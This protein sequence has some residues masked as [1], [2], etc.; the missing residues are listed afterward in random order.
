MG[1]DDTRSTL[2][3][4]LE[5]VLYEPLGLCIESTRGF[6]ED[7]DL[8]IGEDCPGDGYSLFFSSGE[9]QSSFSDFCLP[10]IWE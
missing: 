4:L 5:G 3:E 6:I 1:D 2:H 8:R 7:E 9:L 10:T